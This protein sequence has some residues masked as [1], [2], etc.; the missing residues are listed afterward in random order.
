M[1]TQ[2]CGLV[3]IEPGKRVQVEGAGM[4][5]VGQRADQL[6]EGKQLHEAQHDQRRERI[7]RQRRKSGGDKPATPA[8]Q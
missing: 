4:K 7:L 2:E 8:A 3:A 5:A 6:H 1:A